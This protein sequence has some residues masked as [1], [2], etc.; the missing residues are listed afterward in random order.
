MMA[1]NGWKVVKPRIPMIK[2]RYG[3][4]N[5]VTGAAAAPS[6]KS[7]TSKVQQ[8]NG[9]A[10]G[11]NVTILPTIDDIYLPPRFQRRPLDDREIE[12]INRGGP[13]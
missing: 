10:T 3:G 13:E 2:F 5:R 11:P 8:G 4:I 1:S 12:Y 9:G 7:G 6:I